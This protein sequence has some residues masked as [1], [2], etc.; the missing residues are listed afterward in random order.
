MVQNQI[1]VKGTS[2]M[3]VA[4]AALLVQAA[5]KYAAK[6]YVEQ[7]NKQINAKSIM[8]V[9]TLKIVDGETFL[10]VTEGSDEKEASLEIEKLLS[11]KK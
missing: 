6:V 10:V 4:P 8:G 9:M 7:D 1:T 11:G 3:S 5:S 2:R